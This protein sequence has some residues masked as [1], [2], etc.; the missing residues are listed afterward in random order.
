M[1]ADQRIIANQ[2]WSNVNLPMTSL[3]CTYESCHRTNQRI[4]W[5]LVTSQDPGIVLCEALEPSD[6]V[7]VRFV[8]WWV[9][10]IGN[11]W[12]DV[13]VYRSWWLHGWWLLLNDW[14]IMSQLQVR[15]TS[16]VPAAISEV[17]TAELPRPAGSHGVADG[18]LRVH[19]S[20]LEAQWS[21]DLPVPGAGNLSFAPVCAANFGAGLDA[22][23]RHGG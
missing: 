10:A 17:M 12:F 5:Q 14:F 4:H 2:C 18:T 20:V 15:S 19:H 7:D 13:A 9:D 1:I 11:R 21:P 23:R 6:G 16:W 8:A 3:I 22:T